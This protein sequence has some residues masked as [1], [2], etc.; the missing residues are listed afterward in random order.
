MVP[1]LNTQDSTP[2]CRQF[3]NR[4]HNITKNDITVIITSIATGT[5]AV[6]CDLNYFCGYYITS[7][8]VAADSHP[9]S[10]LCLL[11]KNDSLS[12]F[13]VLV[14]IKKG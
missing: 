1:C 12:L 6:A 11:N 5:L 8:A 13:S 9:G 4:L 2:C 10:K 14:I 7:S 3:V